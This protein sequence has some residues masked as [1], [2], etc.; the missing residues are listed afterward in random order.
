MNRGTVGI[1]IRLKLQEKT[2]AV[3]EA[4]VVLS[5][6]IRCALGFTAARHHPP[7]SEQKEP[8]TMKTAD[9]E[10]ISDRL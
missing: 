6:P 4:R 2:A 9:E 7:T 5:R 10:L 8:F 1:S 3:F